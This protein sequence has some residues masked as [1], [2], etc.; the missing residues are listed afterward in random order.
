M[1]KKREELE[2]RIRV[3]IPEVLL[4]GPGTLTVSPPG[5]VAVK[6]P[7]CE[8]RRPK[9]ALAAPLPDT[10]LAF[11]A[12]G[13]GKSPRFV[14]HRE[15]HL[16][17]SIALEAQTRDTVT[18]CRE[19]ISTSQKDKSFQRCDRLTISLDTSIF[20]LS[21][22]PHAIIPTEDARALELSVRKFPLIPDTAEKEQRVTFLWRLRTKPLSDSPRLTHLDPSVKNSTPEPWKSPF[23]NWPA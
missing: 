16:G 18:N 5:S 10:S 21:F 1:V 17:T 4:E 14:G 9:P 3:H 20:E 15:L 11:A 12:C 6:G 22:K 8:R 13:F 2:G 23:S 7:G 19:T